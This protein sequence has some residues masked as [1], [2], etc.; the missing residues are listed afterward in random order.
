MDYE[1]ALTR[2][3]NMARASGKDA[4]VIYSGGTYHATATFKPDGANVVIIASATP[5]EPMPSMFKD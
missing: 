2:A 3:D 1:A 4:A 5:I